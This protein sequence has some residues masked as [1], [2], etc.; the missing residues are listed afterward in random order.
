MF[1]AIAMLLL[2]LH[3]PQSSY[4]FF[5]FQ[6]AYS[7]RCSSLEILKDLR[8]SHSK[9]LFPGVSLSTALVGPE[10]GLLYHGQSDEEA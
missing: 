10:D 4:F 8:M 6:S 9:K 2:M 5:L 3:M 1:A 7:H